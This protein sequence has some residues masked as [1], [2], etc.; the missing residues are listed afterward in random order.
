MKCRTVSFQNSRYRIPGT[1]R[2]ESSQCFQSCQPAERTKRF[3]CPCQQLL[4]SSPSTGSSTRPS[5]RQLQSTTRWHE[6]PQVK[7]HPKIPHL[8]FKPLTFVPSRNT[9]THTHPHTHTRALCDCTWRFK[10]MD[11]GQ[12]G[13]EH[14]LSITT[15]QRKGERTHKQPSTTH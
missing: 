6:M 4:L 13:T 3:Q 14:P 10:P 5:K 7:L 9:R 11:L 1:L 2:P 12:L 8:T 15:K